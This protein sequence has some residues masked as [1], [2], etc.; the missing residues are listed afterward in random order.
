MDE[1]NCENR[2]T[3][4]KSKTIKT[5]ITEIQIYVVINQIFLFCQQQAC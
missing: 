4:I 3:K 1:V 2:E 5:E